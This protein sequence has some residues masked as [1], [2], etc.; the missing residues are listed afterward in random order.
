[1]W[2]YKSY[3]INTST[4]ISEICCFSDCQEIPWKDVTTDPVLPVRHGT[5]VLLQLICPQ[6]F[7][8]GGSSRAIC[9]N[10]D[11]QSTNGNTPFCAQLGNYLL[12]YPGG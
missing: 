12:C 4:T 10:G 11:L 7:V 3:Q 9:Q 5:E 1:M 2:V 8:I 6:D